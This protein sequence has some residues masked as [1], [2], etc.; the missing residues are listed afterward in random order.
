MA[1]NS[2]VNIGI[3]F[4][5]DSKEVEQS[6]NKLK[7]SLQEIQK[8]KPENFKNVFIVNIIKQSLIK[9]FSS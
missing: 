9:I 8:I 3:K 6:L 5:T 1:N 4:K 7:K 2:Q